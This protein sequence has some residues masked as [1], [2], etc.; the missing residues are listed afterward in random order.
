MQSIQEEKI[1]SMLEREPF[2][3]R[4]GRELGDL[5]SEA[6][7][8]FAYLKVAFSSD[9]P[10][11][12]LPRSF[13]QRV[14]EVFKHPIQFIKN[15]FSFDV[16]NLGYIYKPADASADFTTDVALVDRPVKRR[17]IKKMLVA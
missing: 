13:V 14:V 8:P 4:L 2:F 17:P 1:F 7:H 10:D 15:A 9:N 3:K 11:N 16:I 6:R 12:W 5:S